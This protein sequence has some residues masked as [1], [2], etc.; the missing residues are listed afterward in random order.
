MMA[1]GCLF[2]LQQ[3]GVDVPGEIAVAGFD[4]IPTLRDHTPSLSTVALPLEEIGA[5]AVDLAGRAVLPG[6]IETH[7]HP[8]FFGLTLAAAVEAGT[9]DVDGTLGRWFSADELRNDGLVVRYAREA[10]AAA[11]HASWASALRAIAQFDCSQRTA[12]ISCPVTVVAAE[13]DTVSDVASMKA[14]H[15]RIPGSDF[16]VR[17]GAWHMSIFDD[18]AAVARIL[19]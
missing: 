5:R 10:V 18:P 8:V 14:M 15:L 2:A 6:F 3:A 19:L 7:N 1:L 11:D 12:S 16:I 17:A 9:V 13:H 4:D